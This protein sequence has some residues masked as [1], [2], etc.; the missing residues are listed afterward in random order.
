MMSRR[1]MKLAIALSC[2]PFLL[3]AHSKDPFVSYGIVGFGIEMYNPTCAFAC[4]QVLSLSEL[5]CSTPAAVDHL[6]GHSGRGFDTSNKCFASDDSFLLSLAWCLHQRCNNSQ[7]KVWILDRFWE[8]DVQGADAGL[9]YQFSEALRIYGNGSR[10]VLSLGEPLKEPN[11]VGVENWSVAES[12]MADFAW[13]EK[14]HSIYGLSLLFS[15]ILLPLILTFANS[16]LTAVSPGSEGLLLSHLIY[17]SLFREPG[18]FAR[19]LGEAASLGRGQAILILFVI[20]MNILFMALGFRFSIPNIFF[21]SSTKA[22]LVILAN[23][24]G[25]LAFANLP[26]VLLYISRTNPLIRLTGWSYTTFALLHRCVAYICIAEATIHSIIY[27]AMHLSVL[28]HKFT[29]QYWNIGMLGTAV[30]LAM[31][32]LSLP[33]VR[34]RWYEF[35]I[36]THI[37]LAIV[38]VV[39]CYYHIYTKF[40]HHWGYENWILLAA[41]IW[42]LETLV[43]G[44]KTAV[45]GLRYARTEEVDDE[46]LVVTVEGVKG[47]GV[48]YLY[49]PS[50]GL[51]VWENH[52]FS[53]MASAVDRH[54]E[55][56]EKDIGHGE[57]TFDLVGSEDEDDDEDDDN[58]DNGNDNDDEGRDLH[59][60]DRKRARSPSAELE[61]EG[62]YQRQEGESFQTWVNQ[63]SPL[64]PATPHSDTAMVPEFDRDEEAGL[65]KSHSNNIHNNIVTGFSF[66]IRRERGIT[67]RIFR[68]ALTLPVLIEGPYP[69]TISLSNAALTSPHVVCIAGG[70]GIAAIVPVLRIR[71]SA[72]MGR[73]ALYFGTR[74]EGLVRTC[75]LAELMD[76]KD[77]VGIDV[78]IMVK[79]RWNL[80]QVVLRETACDGLHDRQIQRGGPGDVIV[81]VCGPPS[82]VTDVRWAVVEANQR[83]R[84][85]AGI[86]RLIYESF[87]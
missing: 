31:L 17:P 33:F 6:P 20:A 44:V 26:V 24:S 52:P 69:T 81:I 23:R 58:D 71:A 5:N 85:K 79:G 62:P 21:S 50:M 49:F 9:K 40:G 27:F 68:H 2:L 35:F 46:Y 87:K 28:L 73:T 34:S 36:D 47:T 70:V 84:N 29:Q 64:T 37:T 72:G 32:P 59:L 3:S 80:R 22:T 53:I 51:R 77:A 8:R 75:G 7:D 83:R 4:Q 67:A 60:P 30:L 41:F 61:I 65:F 10:Q 86:V 48:A 1:V 74:S 55:K 13:V 63:P 56:I 45:N 57:P 11:E 25:I 43:R 15:M 66:L 39:T 18:F 14:R 38:G 78:Q 82:M 42:I 12:S 19:L 54:V 16:I 76:R